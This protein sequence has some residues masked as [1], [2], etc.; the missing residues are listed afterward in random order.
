MN[1]ASG[2]HV[3]YVKSRWEKRVDESLKESSLESFVP[4]TRTLRQ[5]SD[6]K[7]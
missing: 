3:M 2:W 5:W 6:R 4:L 7:K 1:Y